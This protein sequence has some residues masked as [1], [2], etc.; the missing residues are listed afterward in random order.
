MNGGTAI[1]SS[2]PSYGIFCFGALT[3]EGGGTLT[4]TGGNLPG[5]SVERTAG[6][7]ANGG[8][9]IQ[10]GTIH[11]FGGACLSNTSVGAGIWSGPFIRI[12]GGTV[13]A[14]ANNTATNYAM[15]SNGGDIT[16]NDGTVTVTAMS[17]ITQSCRGILASAYSVIINGGTVIANVSSQ[18]RAQGIFAK[19]ISI[20]N[21]KV[22]ATATSV[23]PSNTRQIRGLYATNGIAVSGGSVKAF[24]LGAAQNSYGM[25]SDTIPCRVT[26]GTVYA[27]GF[28]SA[29]PDNVPS[30]SGLT[31]TGS[32]TTNAAESSLGAVIWDGTSKNYYM[33]SVAPANVAKTL[34]LAV[35]APIQVDIALSPV[36]TFQ[37]G[38]APSN[39][40][41][42]VGSAGQTPST[43]HFSTLEISPDGNNFTAVDSSNYS[44][45]YGS[46][47]IALN[48]SWLNT[49]TPG[50]YTLRVNLAGAYAGMQ[51]STQ[52]TVTAPAASA[53][54]GDA[55]ISGTV[56][57]PLT[58][59]TATITLTNDTFTNTSYVDCASW[60]TNLPAGITASATVAGGNVATITFN[61][62]PTAVRT[63]AMAVTIPAASLVRNAA[64]TVTANASAK[65]D[66]AFRIYVTLPSG[67]T[68]TIT[69]SPSDAVE[70]I[71][72]KIQN[73]TSISPD[74]QLLYSG[75]TKL[76]DGRTLADY[77]IQSGATIRLERGTFTITYNPNGGSGTM[78]NGT[79]TAGTAFT[80][81][82]CTFTAPTG[83]QFKEWAIGST[84][85]TKVNAG[86]TH[87]FTGNTTVYAIWEAIPTYT[88]SVAPTAYDF[89]TK[90]KNYWFR[91]AAQTY[92]VT[93]TGTGSVTLNALTGSTAF[94]IVTPNN[95]TD[96]LA[97]NASRTFTIQ[98]NSGL[99][100]GTY[101]ETFNVST[102][103]GTS[104][105]AGAKFVVEGQMQVNIT[106]NPANLTIINGQSIVLTANVAG[107]TAG[108]S[109]TY[110]WTIPAV[111][112]T[113]VVSTSNPATFSPT[114]STTYQVEVTEVNN[115]RNTATATVTVIP[116]TYAVTYNP[117]GGSGTMAPGTATEGVAF[118]LP[119][120]GFTAP[121]GQ[122]FKEWAIGSASGPNVAP[123]SA[124]TFTGNT[125][126]YAIWEAIPPALTITVS[127]VSTF[128]QGNAPQLV[129][130]IGEGRQSFD[131]TGNY[132]GIYPTSELT[133]ALGTVG[134]SGRDGKVENGSIKLTLYPSY[135]NTLAQGEY[136]L[137]I[138]LKGSG[139]PDFVQTRIVVTAPDGTGADIPKTGDGSLP[140]LWLGL[141]L[142]AGAGLAASAVLG[143]RKRDSH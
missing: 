75:T 133:P 62:T 97:P 129:V 3:I 71:K 142:L 77:N 74:Q 36:A 31:I 105:T 73:A 96:A 51:R 29:M 30:P 46:I 109:Y 35:A 64:V 117:N 138:G 13:N 65:W 137:R 58:S 27:T 2:T 18:D 54:I 60:F 7:G 11:T 87:T 21:G 79:A 83:Q 63:A 86:G 103:A 8:L 69:A 99:D 9:T 10:S 130:T 140:G 4:A 136:L 38:N 45:N 78:T 135:L 57:M 139:N 84:S 19:D 115:S 37:Q 41:I 49:L 98:P 33:G 6:I 40:V 127:P 72:S 55:T 128:P 16:I 90:S 95:W 131:A 39:L 61:G 14:T 120:C 141:L 15:Y 112:T 42:N 5:D 119:S 56:N 118:T 52:L 44:V 108:A 67:S 66:I 20:T 1:G 102:T 104:A 100:T 111:F 143:R 59:Q 34:K 91:P 93:N 43:G 113:N 101:D 50:V 76:E 94:E 53:A 25:E 32:T 23:S 22:T 24:A 122:R 26:G 106:G 89:G 70:S 132:N 68:I 47:H 110:A 114:A 12:N 121:T 92:T 48:Q 124:Y 88:I 123:G 82:A 116:A 80:L 126:V 134:T 81:P 85:G 17:N 28:N 125:T 107:G